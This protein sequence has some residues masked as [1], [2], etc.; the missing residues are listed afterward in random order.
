MPYPSKSRLAR[1]PSTRLLLTLAC[2]L[3][4]SSAALATTVASHGESQ[5]V[6]PARYFAT[7]AAERTARAAIKQRFDA[8]RTSNSTLH[9]E[10][11]FHTLEALFGECL[12]HYAYHEL[13]AAQDASDRVAS[14]ARDDVEALCGD[15]ASTA[16]ALVRT[17]PAAARW[18]QPYAYL[19]ARS[20]RA[21]AHAL[22]AVAKPMA[23]AADTALGRFEHAHRLATQGTGFPTMTVGSRVMNVA[24]DFHTL[25]ALPDEA[26]R[27]QAWTLHHDAMLQRKPAL[28][29]AL[30]GIAAL[31]DGLAVTRGYTSAPEQAYAG[32]GLGVTEVD[33]ALHAL[34]SH[35]SSFAAYQAL[36]ETSGNSDPAPWNDEAPRAGFS[37]P[38]MSMEQVRQ[39][40]M[41]AA[42]RLG[43]EHVAQIG[44]VLDPAGGRMD[45]ASQLGR[46]KRDAFSITAPHSTS[47]LYV[48][49][50]RGDTESDVEVVHEGA[51]AVHGQLMNAH[52]TS[53]LFRHGTS[54][55]EETFAL[56][57]EFLYRD[58]LVSEATTL[59][60]RDYYQRGLLR[61]LA[62]QLFISAEEAQLEAAIH[63]GVHD[64]TVRGPDDLDALAVQ[65]RTLHEGGFSGHAGQNTTWAGKRLFYQ[66]PLYLTNY[67]FAGLVAVKLY[68][69]SA[70][71]PGFAARYAQ[72]Q[73]RG[74][75]REPGEVVE[76]LIG[77]PVDW[78]QLA[79][80]DVTLFNARV[81]ALNHPDPGQ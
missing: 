47:V 61:D 43:P 58:Q 13:I 52:G 21:E 60:A 4:S 54:W 50:R 20:A 37:P 34:Q 56:L 17:A 12:D 53:P 25:M 65:M 19:A 80:D 22:P 70:E 32:M 76:E 49:H 2:L 59:G 73:A 6:D 72:V 41:R 48:G 3:A 40:A 11:D 69:L 26:A 75:D 42:A 68:A 81:A 77:H 66:D 10:T 28:A 15:I 23:A 46:R 16:K 64:G 44:A 24:D 33:T 7:P 9:I 29:D 51:H 45:F 74:F 55:L 39:I 38:A 1:K 31:R 5:S 78:T 57:D 71:D 30:I 27:K 35:A 62:L 79:D 63:Q 14:A 36:S 8:L 18:A 67:L